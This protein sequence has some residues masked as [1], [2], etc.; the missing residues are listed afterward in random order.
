MKSILLIIALSLGS[1]FAATMPF[2][3]IQGVVTGLN[4]KTVEVR[5]K[6]N[7]LVIPRKLVKSS[8]KVNDPIELS[9]SDADIQQVKIKK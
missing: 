5:T 2:Q 1:V 4:N 6:Q 7:T 3:T 8:I 9:L